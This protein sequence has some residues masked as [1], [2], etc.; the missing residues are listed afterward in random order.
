MIN[1]FGELKMVV[2]FKKSGVLIQKNSKREK[3]NVHNRNNGEENK[4]NHMT[5]T[6]YDLSMDCI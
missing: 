2:Q 6:I 1:Y 5:R 4:D 3:K